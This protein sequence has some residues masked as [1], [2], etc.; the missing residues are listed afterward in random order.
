MGVL[1][2]YRPPIPDPETCQFA[3]KNK[4]KKEKRQKLQ[5]N[6]LKQK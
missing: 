5:S 2:P 4:R 6:N 3:W 1:P